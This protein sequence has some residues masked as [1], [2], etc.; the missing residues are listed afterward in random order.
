MAQDEED[1][2]AMEMQDLQ[3][4]ADLPLEQLLARYGYTSSNPPAATPPAAAPPAMALSGPQTP[5]SAEQANK[6]E[7]SLEGTSTAER[8]PQT[9]Y[10]EDP[11]K[12]IMKPASQKQPTSQTTLQVPEV[13]Q[14]ATGSR[15]PGIDESGA[16][17][18]GIL[19]LLIVLL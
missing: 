18:T 16:E 4:D 17:P 15:Q 7:T 3:D 2:T 11:G 6:Q 13:M 14:V 19:K 10:E 9:N 12:N 5:A 8:L 1:D